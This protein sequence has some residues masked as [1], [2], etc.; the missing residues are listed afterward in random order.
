MVFAVR[1]N[2]T[3]GFQALPA[4][5]NK[6]RLYHDHG[7]ERVSGLL[8]AVRFSMGDVKFCSKCGTAVWAPRQRACAAPHLSDHI[9]GRFPGL[10]CASARAGP[11]QQR[12]IKVLVCVSGFILL[13]VLAVMGGCVCIGYRAKKKAD[14]IRKPTDNDLNKLAG[15]LGVR[16]SKQGGGSSSSSSSSSHLNLRLFPP[17]V[18]SIHGR[19][20]NRKQSPLRPG[21]TVVTAILQLAA[22]TNPSSKFR[23]SA[24]AA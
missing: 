20:A 17:G 5:R 3:L 14:E 2:A 13:V 19:E 12:P 21:L 16:S 22:T 18:D 11:K 24:P 7:K 23:R 1:R 10:C 15:A 9:T 4:R 6:L 8:Q